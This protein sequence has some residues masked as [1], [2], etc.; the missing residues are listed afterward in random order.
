GRAIRGRLQLRRQHLGF[1]VE[2][3]WNIILAHGLKARHSEHTHQDAEDNDCRDQTNRDRHHEC[4]DSIFNPNTPAVDPG[5]A[6]GCD[7]VRDCQS[8][9]ESKIGRRLLGSETRQNMLRSG[10]QVIFPAA[11]NARLQVFAD[12]AHLRT[13]HRT[14]EVRR[15][16]R[17]G[18]RA[19][20][21]ATSTSRPPAFKSLS[22]SGAFRPSSEPHSRIKGINRCF[23]ASLPRVRRDLTVPSD[24]SVISA[25]SSYDM[26]SMS[27]RMTVVRYGSGTLRNSSSTR[28]CISLWANCSSGDS[29]WSTNGSFEA[30]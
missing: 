18:L 19:V 25:I 13:G 21:D 1:A 27:R 29:P 17:F 23:S 11:I 16:Q 20:H 4:L 26:S 2:H 28:C 30:P 9:P 6:G 12:G 22:D 3:E 14:V 7:L 5:V 15:K 10:H 8:Q 24:T